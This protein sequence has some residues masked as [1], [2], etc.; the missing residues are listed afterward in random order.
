MRK[1]A[2][3]LMF[4]S[5][6]GGLSYA[7]APSVSDVFEAANAAYD[8]GD[9]NTAIALYEGLRSESVETGTLYFNLAAA[10]YRSG[11]LGLSLL[12]L[13]EA[14]RFFPRDESLTRAVGIIHRERLD[15]LGDEVSL[16]DSTAELT[17]RFVT[18]N[19]LGVII[20]ALWGIVF[21]SATLW[22]LMVG[23]RVGL[24][25]LLTVSSVVCLIF[26]LLLAVRVYVG[27]YRPLAVVVAT[28]T[29][30]YSGADSAYLPLFELGEAA[31][32]R[33]VERVGADWGRV[34]LADGRQAWLQLA[35]LRE[36]GLR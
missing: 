10:Y 12:N 5:L 2:L 35:D 17:V 6:W 13:R 21:L 24:T 18:L 25:P 33:I 15:L 9:Y 23:W 3:I 8:S 32:V 22:V 20:A 4:C 7:Q 14:E 36:V 28:R 26:A 11:A 27:T 16:L 34:L 31:E 1:Y 19:E 29:T 30:A